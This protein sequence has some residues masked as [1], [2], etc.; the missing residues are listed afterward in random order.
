MTTKNLNDRLVE[1]RLR[2][3]I[4]TMRELRDELRVTSEQLAFVESE[5]QDKEMRAMVAETAD[6]ALEHHE[7]QRNLETIQKYHRRL[8]ASIAEYELRQDMLLDKLGN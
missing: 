2:H 4:Q 6:A 8:L 7:A 1:R 3:G 5:A